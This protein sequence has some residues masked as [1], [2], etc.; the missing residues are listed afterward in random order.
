MLLQITLNSSAKFETANFE[1]AGAV[2]ARLH[3]SGYVL[4][5][6]GFGVRPLLLGR[7]G[8]VVWYGTGKLSERERLILCDRSGFLG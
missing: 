2:C 3:W 6:F 5:G 4:V 1:S 8:R 7:G